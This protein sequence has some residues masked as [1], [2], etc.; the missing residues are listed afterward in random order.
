MK[1]KKR[2]LKPNNLPTKLPFF[3]TLIA[4]IAMDYY[5]APQWVCGAVGLYV[6]LA[7]IV[8]IYSMATEEKQDLF[9]N[10]D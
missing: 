4:M 3:Q 8:A 5:N 6:L 7:W 2:V 10:D 9:K 1:K